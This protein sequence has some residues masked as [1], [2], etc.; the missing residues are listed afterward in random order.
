MRV[1][2]LKKLIYPQN[3]AFSISTILIVSCLF[4]S[5][6]DWK[7]KLKDFDSAI[8]KRDFKGCTEYRGLHA[9]QI[10]DQKDLLIG[11]HENTITQLLGHPTRLDL[12]KKMTRS[13]FYA[14]E[15]KNCED[16]TGQK[17]L[18]IDYNSLSQVKLVMIQNR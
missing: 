10:V 12:G 18:V 3:Q 17:F 14:I 13:S 11:K 16:N 6:C 2:H 4:L 5:S 7:I 1:K 8:W 15:N 9:Q